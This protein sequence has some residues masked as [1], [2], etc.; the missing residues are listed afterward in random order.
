MAFEGEDRC[1]ARVIGLS[2]GA[3]FVSRSQLDL[4][5]HSVS[6]PTVVPFE[7]HS[8][9]QSNC[10]IVAD[11]T[12][13]ANVPACKVSCRIVLGVCLSENRP[14][15]QHVPNRLPTARQ[16]NQSGFSTAVDQWR[17]TRYRAVDVVLL[18]SECEPG[19]DHIRTD[20]SVGSFHRDKTTDEGIKTYQ[21]RIVTVPLHKITLTITVYHQRTDDE[22]IP[23][24]RLQKTFE[25]FP[26]GKTWSTID[27]VATAV[28]SNQT[29][30]E[31]SDDISEHLPKE[32]INR[33][34]SSTGT[35]HS[36]Q[37]RYRYSCRR[38]Y[39]GPSCNHFCAPRDSALGHYNCHPQTGAIICHPGW[40]GTWCNVA[41]CPAGC[42]HGVC[43]EP[44]ICTCSDGWSGPTCDVCIPTPGCKHG[45][46][47]FNVDHADFEPY[48][49]QCSV[50]WT[51]MLCTINICQNGGTC[52]NTPDESG[53]KPLYVCM[54]REGYRGTHCEQHIP[55]CAYH[56]CSGAGR[57]QRHFP[58]QVCTRL[59]TMFRFQPDGQCDCHEGHYGSQCQFNQTDCNQNPC[60]GE[61]SEC[62]PTARFVQDKHDLRTPMGLQPSGQ[63]RGFKCLCEPGRYGGNCEQELNACEREQCFNGGRCVSM[64]HGYQC[65]CPPRFT[66]KH[67]QIPVQSCQEISCANNGECL[68]GGVHF[69][70]HC[71]FG[72]TGPTCR[73]NVNECAEIPR[74]TGQ[75]LCEHGAGCRDLPGT[76]Q[77]LCP[78]GWTGKH[79]EIPQEPAQCFSGQNC[80]RTT[81]HLRNVTQSQQSTTHV[82]TLFTIVTITVPITIAASLCGL[83]L[84]ISN[85]RSR[86][87]GNRYVTINCDNHGFKPNNSYG[88][89]EQDTHYRNVFPA[90]Q[91]HGS[92]TD[93]SD[94]VTCKKNSSIVSIISDRTSDMTD[95]LDHL[96]HSK[97]KSI[98]TQK[99]LKFSPEVLT[100]QTAQLHFDSQPTYA[101]CENLIS[102]EH[103]MTKLYARSSPPP[104]YEPAAVIG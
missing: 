43:E 70:C 64:R 86:V 34:P 53:S 52:L 47:K 22:L 16:P 44:N 55:G 59:F 5:I 39:Y 8:E 19:E 92:S 36:L 15:A 99:H 4:Q 73:Q 80:T 100:L 14:I 62:I 57:C 35:V 83:V 26:V 28:E 6:L 40:T 89:S 96:P 95:P 102:D 25:R 33:R 75:A 11:K 17:R 32:S 7:Q 71:P 85:Y 48:T 60:M 94:M 67:C 50:D 72:W 88:P 23:I 46:C 42:V 98:V 66:G 21:I 54:C 24:D 65:I 9:R 41:M 58:Y 10:C 45:Q 13:E 77:C 97:R 69:S 93:V 18:P 1:H 104:P 51:G 30:A 68:E 27:M 91:S 87:K 81:Q 2:T 90:N 38:N 63:P 20:V 82:V 74:L 101:V 37:I 61:L 31:Q 84:L 76:Y 3:D 29:K 103:F 12:A 49:C 79:C 78:A 56:G